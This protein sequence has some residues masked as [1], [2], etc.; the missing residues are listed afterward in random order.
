MTVDRMKKRH[1]NINNEILMEKRV[2]LLLPNIDNASIVYY[3]YY[4]CCNDIQAL[5][6]LDHPGIVRLYNT[7]QDYGTLYYQMDF[8][9]GRDLFDHLHDV[10]LTGFLSAAGLN[11]SGDDSQ[12][13]QVGCSWSQAR[14]YLAEAINAVEHMHRYVVVSMGRAE[15]SIQ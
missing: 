5:N 9:G 7:F 13:A 8:I 1:P 10:Q 3:M 15:R 14:F 12:R 2:T 6:R 11:G 4:C